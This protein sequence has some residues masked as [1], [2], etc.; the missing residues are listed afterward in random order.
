MTAGVMVPLEIEILKEVCMLLPQRVANSNL[1]RVADDR[2]FAEAVY[3]VALADGVTDRVG[4]L[5]PA[6]G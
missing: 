5:D 4:Y 3:K 6:A 2:R 1:S